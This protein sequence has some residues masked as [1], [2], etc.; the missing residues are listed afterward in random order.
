MV[1]NVDFIVS[2]T[3]LNIENNLKWK[4]FVMFATVNIGAMLPFS[5]YV[6]VIFTRSSITNFRGLLLTLLVVPSMLPETK[7]RS[8]DEMDI[9][10]GSVRAED[11]DAKIRETQRG[12]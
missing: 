11:R 4:I 12:E 1:H 5:M 8:L 9:I 6:R 7:G 10:F 2:R 3:T